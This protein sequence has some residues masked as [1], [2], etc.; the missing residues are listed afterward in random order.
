M[1]PSPRQLLNEQG[2]RRIS[3]FGVRVGSWNV[4]SIRRRGIE[5]CEEL[6]KRKVDVCCLQEVRFKGQ[7]AR[8]IGVKER[9]YKLWWA[10]TDSGTGG[11]GI[12][13]KEE[14]CDKVVEVR[15]RN[16]RIM[17]VVMTFG[18]EILRMICAYGPQS[19]RPFT[20]KQQFY[21]DLAYEWNLCSSAEMV[22]GLG[23]FN[24]H[25][26]KLI[27]GFEGIHGGYGFGVRNVEGRMLLEFCDEKDL[28]VANTWFKKKRKVTYSAGGNETEI[29]FVLVGKDCRKYLK[30]V[31]VIPGELQHGL[32]VADI[33]KRKL[34]GHVKRNKVLRRRLWKLKNIEVRNIFKHRVQ[35]SVDMEAPDLWKSFKDGVLN[36][37]D[38][39]CGKRVLRREGGNTWWW[40][41]EVK[42][43]ITRKKEAYRA[44]CKNRSENNL[45]T[46]KALKNKAK[47]IVASAMKKEA[48]RE[49]DNLSRNP[50]NI[51]KFLKRMRKDGKDVEGG[52][53]IRD[54]RGKLGL[55]A[56]DR[57]RIWKEHME[58]IM[59]EENNWDQ[60]VNADMVEGPVERVSHAEIIN[61]IKTMK[62]GKAAGP[63]EVNFEMIAASGEV[64]EK[65]MR[66][67]CQRVLDGKGM[68]DDW[69]TSMVVPIYKGKGDVLNCGSYRG[70]KLL[71]H[72]MKIVERVLEKRIRSIVEL[73]EMQFGFMPGKGT[74][75]ALF[76]V[77]RLQEEYMQ[78]DRK[79]YLCFVDLE[80]AFDRVPRKVVEWSLRVKGVPEVI[81]KA[82][83]SLYEGATTRVRVGS[84]VSDK[85]S[86]K[87]GVHQ[88]SVLS[89]LLF[90]IVMDVVTEDA[91][92]GTLH[93]IL[94]AD[95]LVLMGESMED[96][97][98][99]FSLWKATLESKGM[100]VNI[101][102][103]KL[104]VSG[105]EGETSRSKIDPCGMCGKRVMANAILCIKCGH[106]IHRRCTKR[107]KLT[108]ALAQSFVCGR[109]DCMRA[110]TVSTKEKLCDGVETVKGFCYLGD[111][112]NASGGCE[113]AVTARARIGWLKFR[114]CGEVLYGKRFSLRLKG[115]V[116]QSCVQS[117]M[118]YGSE[119]WCLNEKEVAILRRTERAMLR[120]MC[121]VKLMDRKNSNELMAMLGLTVS[122]EMAAKTNALRWFGH[123]LRTEEDNPVK[124]ALNFEVDGKR[125][126][127]RPKSTWKGKVK[128][129]MQKACLKEED[130]WDR[131]KWRKCLWLFKNEVNPATS[132]DGDTTG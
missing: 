24:C 58:K 73:N 108:V 57:K 33:D 75:D 116:Y 118:L 124:K 16:D 86:V 123:V 115:K 76:L 36:A 35:D 9:R 127:G 69:K 96:L 53:C 90:A 61:A 55:S 29:D 88:G 54:E 112:L 122:I 44:L 94:Y 56:I 13:I 110:G 26:G 5:I 119:T 59:N 97:Q 60:V 130:A 125:K 8:F 66:E 103:T 105:T 71:E 78:K 80:K 104:M 65:V 22:L 84:A 23:D 30:D 48:E 15:R 45:A 132:V 62:T 38:E 2:V 98:S 87:V 46:Y 121:G 31:K 42:E 129:G 52:Q 128:I 34:T 74:V 126:K 47:K 113:A 41:A 37:C 92:N 11:V 81:V 39:L 50:N 77:R 6:R 100:K 101:N 1:A 3:G 107:K 25:V 18:K 20:E 21:D 70:V 131:N 12:L 49:I 99:K 114:E 106:W 63:S 117:A 95:D 4:G 68:P 85:F 28:C 10:G 67:L 51:F 83:M 91:R 93:E 79:L 89:P 109:C 19:G 7:G 14:L 17:A 43:A 40:N 64:G 72:G 120:A 102:K 111:R 32:V 27:D 82:V